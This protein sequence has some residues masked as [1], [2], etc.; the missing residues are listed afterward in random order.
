MLVQGCTNG[1]LGIKSQSGGRMYQRSELMLRGHNNSTKRSTRTR[2]LTVRHE[3]EGMPGVAILPVSEAAR[4]QLVMSQTHSKNTPCKRQ[5]ILPMPRQVSSKN[6]SDALGKSDDNTDD[7][8]D[9]ITI[10]DDDDESQEET[11]DAICH[12]HG[13]SLLNV[14]GPSFSEVICMLH[15]HMTFP[16]CLQS[17]YTQ[18]KFFKKILDNPVSFAT[19]KVKQGLIFLLDHDD[20]LLCIPDGKLDDVSICETIISHAHSL[21]AHLSGRK[22]FHYLRSN[23]WWPGIVWVLGFHVTAPLYF[24]IDWRLKNEKSVIY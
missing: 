5:Q 3:G 24:S 6:I 15:P 14:E 16:Q 7:L 17:L 20:E 1:G 8:P 18:D 21:L 22:T 4:Q 9:L 12:S 13:D 19:F 23:V 2:R 11:R 10:D